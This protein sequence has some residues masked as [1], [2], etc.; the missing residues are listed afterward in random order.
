MSAN[1]SNLDLANILLSGK[2]TI[3]DVTKSKVFKDD[4]L[5]IG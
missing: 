3:L 2:D 1:T 5:N 4:K